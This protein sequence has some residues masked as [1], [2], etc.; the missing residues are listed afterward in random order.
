MIIFLPLCRFVIV[1]DKFICSDPKDWQVEKPICHLLSL[2]LSSLGTRKVPQPHLPKS[3]PCLPM[4]T[5]ASALETLVSTLQHFSS[6]ALGPAGCLLQSFFSLD[7]NICLRGTGCPAA[8]TCHPQETPGHNESEKGFWKDI[9]FSPL[10]SVVVWP[11]WK[12]RRAFRSI[13]ECLTT[14][15]A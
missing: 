1:Q 3:R 7:Q 14:P 2:K 12:L 8:Q 11:D 6:R 9:E 10:L 13:S 5:G 15:S 4:T